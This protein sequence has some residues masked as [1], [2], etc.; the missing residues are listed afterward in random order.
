MSILQTPTRPRMNPSKTKPVSAERVKEMLL[1]ITFVLHAT[2]VVGRRGS[3]SRRA[4]SAGMGSHRKGS[5]RPRRLG[6]ASIPSDLLLYPATQQTT[7][8]RPLG[9]P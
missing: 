9:R 2:R 4:G 3:P 8:S 6:Q 5:R 7:S 1:E